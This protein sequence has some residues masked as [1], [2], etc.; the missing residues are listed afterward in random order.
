MSYFCHFMVCRVT[1]GPELQHENRHL[2]EQG[3]KQSLVKSGQALLFKTCSAM[4]WKNVE[5]AREEELAKWKMFGAPK[6]MIIQNIKK[7]CYK[8][9]QECCWQK[10]GFSLEA[11]QVMAWFLCPQERGVDVRRSK[12]HEVWMGLEEEYNL[13]VK[14]VSRKRRDNGSTEVRRCPSCRSR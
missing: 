7:R 8:S 14:V 12:F 4:L 1:V 10:N 2:R 11:L 3:N 9:R 13:L 5:E 6:P